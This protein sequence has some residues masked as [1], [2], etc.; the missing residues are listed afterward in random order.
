MVQVPQRSLGTDGRQRV[1]V[2]LGRWRGRRPFERLSPPWVVACRFAVTERADEVPEERQAADPEDEGT[3]RRDE[4]E[5][6]PSLA[7]GI[8]RDTPRHPV[9]PELVLH[10]EGQ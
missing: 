1:E 5:R 6:A 2:V 3:D 9:E 10:E 7:R 8:A 4:V